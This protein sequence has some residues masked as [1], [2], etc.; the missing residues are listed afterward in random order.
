VNALSRLPRIVQW[1]VALLLA[2]VYA[3]FGG[4]FFALVFRDWRWLPLLVAGVFLLAPLESLLLTPVYA[5]AGRFRYYSPMLLATRRRGGGLDLHVGTLFDYVARLRWSDRGPRAS[6]I[7]TADI[8]RGLLALA[9]EIESGAL[10]AGA[11]IVATSYFFSDRTVAR[12][13]FELRDAPAAVRHN[14]AAAGLSIAL[15]LSFTRGRPAF[16]DLRRIRQAATTACAL[17]EHAD[18]IR[19]LLRRLPA[20]PAGARP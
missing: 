9:E 13:G 4:A 6:R 1:A 16:P 18:E 12:L 19:R 14:L 11:E 3:G 20:R 15:R 8:L 5:L 2:A 17:A 10:P 7:V